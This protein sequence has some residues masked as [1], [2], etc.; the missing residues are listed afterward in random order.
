MLKLVHLH[1]LLFIVFSLVRSSLDKFFITNGHNATIAKPPKIYISCWCKFR[2][3]L[4]LELFMVFTL[5]LLIIMNIFFC[6]FKVLTKNYWTCI[7]FIGVT[8]CGVLNDVHQTRQ[9]FES[10]DCLTYCF[11]PYYYLIF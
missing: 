2:V 10:D 8:K 11:S 3:S 9:C 7:I 5:K 1:K 4:M 6:D